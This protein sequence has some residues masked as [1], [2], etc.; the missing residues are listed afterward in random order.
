MQTAGDADQAEIVCFDKRQPLSRSKTCPGVDPGHCSA[1]VLGKMTAEG[2]GSPK[3]TRSYLASRADQRKR[4]VKISRGR[5]RRA[6]DRYLC[7][8]DWAASVSHDPRDEIGEW[9]MPHHSIRTRQVSRLVPES[10]WSPLVDIY[11]LRF[12]LQRTLNLQRTSMSN[13]DLRVTKTQS[14]I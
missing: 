12:S 3:S 10:I 1:L 9:A 4:R 8:V 5:A 14:R 11:S 7:I 13:E 2:L 6:A